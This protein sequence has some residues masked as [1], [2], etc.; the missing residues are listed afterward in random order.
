MGAAKFL[1]L[2][3]GIVGIVSFFMPLIA[4]KNSGIEG[5]VS[6]FQIVK[7]LETA[8]EV[9]KGA[10]GEAAAAAEEA[11]SVELKKAAGEANQALSTVK[12]IVLGAYAPSLLML[13]IGVV[14]VA[15]KQFGRL[16]GTGGFLFGLIT[17]GVWAILNAASNEVAADIAKAGGSVDSVKGMGM[18]LLMV[19][20]ALGLIGGLMALIKPE[21]K[22]PVF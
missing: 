20:G 4:V 9:V 17:L 21:R 6:A 22:D 13:I 12:N 19:A 18:H 16:G 14:A 3:G 5:A 8:S 1:V 7:G 2:V 10:A 11:G 15:R